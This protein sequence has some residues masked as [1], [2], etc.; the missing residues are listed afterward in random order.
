MNALAETREVTVR[1]GSF[2]AV[3]S[4]D[5]A[6]SAGEVVG[7]LGAN[8]AGKTTLIRA[9]LGLLRPSRGRALLFGETPSMK[10]RRRVG[11]VP[12]SLGL[13]SDMTVGENWEFTSAAFASGHPPM[14]ESIAGSSGTLVRDLPL[15]LQRRVAFAVAFSHEPELLVLDEP[16][17][18]VGPLGSAR[19]WLDIR[20]SSGRGTGV[21][22][23]T[24]NMEEAEQ[25]DR[26]VVMTAG[27][28]A[29][30]GTS[31]DITAGRQVV[32]VSCAEW[33]RAFA[34]LDEEGFIV[35]ARGGLLR[36]S[37]SPERVRELLETHSLEASVSSVP[38]NIEESFMEVVAG[39]PGREVG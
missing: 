27:R 19:L 38:A 22:V 5:L 26:L 34:L 14:P 33:P 21:L 10:T 18:G 35:Q 11:Y 39:S 17:S 15:G 1:F 31:A 29:A 32:Q 24:H 4:V 25:C 8:G 37:G 16:T 36:V 13:Y 6:V 3:D 2:T 30:R 20:E 23:T 7:L 9:L 28:V 12:Q